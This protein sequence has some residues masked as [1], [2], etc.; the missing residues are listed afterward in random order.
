[1][2]DWFSQFQQPNSGDWF[3]KFQTIDIPEKPQLP[4]L[5]SP[6][7]QLPKFQPTVASKYEGPF[8]F[9]PL[10]RTLGAN[11]G[12][13]A[14]GMLSGPLASEETWA[15]P[16]GK[17]GAVT[18]SL[19]DIAGMAKGASMLGGKLFKAKPKI[20]KTKLASVDLT[21]SLK[22]PKEEASPIQLIKGSENAYIV[23]PNGEKVFN[24]P[25]IKFNNPN[26][27]PKLE[28]PK[29]KPITI[30]KPAP[31]ERI[32]AW[33]NSRR[34]SDPAGLQVERQF[35]DIDA[36]GMGAIQAIE[37]GDP[38]Y[39]KVRQHL[40]TRYN[41]AKEAIPEIKYRKNYLPLLFDNTREEVD[42]A[43]KA[44]EEAKAL[45][46]IKVAKRPG[47]TLTR[48]LED[49]EAGIAKGLKPKFSKPSQILGWYEQALI[50]GVEDRKLF[51][52]LKSE[53][54][55]SSYKKEG[56]EYLDPNS[57][58]KMGNKKQGNVYYA[59]EKIATAINNAI[60]P[61][62][63]PVFSKIANFSRFTK[64]VTLTGG[65]PKTGINWHTLVSIPARAATAQGLTHPIKGV[66]N[67]LRTLYYDVRPAAAQKV[68]D[69]K[70]GR[71]VYWQ[72][73]G[74]NLGAEGFWAG[75]EKA[76]K[77]LARL[78]DWF[79]HASFRQVIPATK[80][81]IADDIQSGLI[82]KGVDPEEA[83]DIVAEYTNTWFGGLNNP[84]RSQGVKDFLQIALLA[85]DWAETKYKITK[86]AAKALLTPG[87]PASQLYLNGVAAMA[88][89][90][91]AAAGIRAS[92]GGKMTPR[93]AGNIPLP[94]LDMP[95]KQAEADP[96]G[97]AFESVE[98]PMRVLNKARSGDVGGVI[99][100]IG[101]TAKNNTSI[102]MQKLVNLIIG[103][104]YYGHPL[105]SKYGN[106]VE[107]KELL[108]NYAREIL[109]MVT[110]QP[111][112]AGVDYGV[113]NKLLNAEGSATG[114]EAAAQA[115]E[116]PI[117]WYRKPKPF[118]N[119]LPKLQK[120]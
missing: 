5:P 29:T 49:Y 113:G 30:S 65:V 52:Y 105:R 17:A 64:N 1:M 114:P 24:Q 99:E 51:E 74:M 97:S 86:G 100:E 27:I 16:Y 8:S 61:K 96:Y 20:S 39:S 69:Q 25:F 53:K 102:P 6:F 14:A 77:G 92:M 59:P 41:I 34:A 115:F 79:S 55:L 58:P 28:A 76:K 31:E 106:E 104:D 108:A 56:W 72:K 57:F 37:S 120:P 2:P 75:Q 90:L 110:L 73:H 119:A 10:R 71:T 44:I 54:L 107:T 35:A 91:G 89:G 33:Y 3:S 9:D 117:R 88:A 84:F 50:K 60:A 43:F 66:K 95:G 94:A 112:Q 7:K 42:T 45:T 36:D 26:E 23:G 62:K 19:L 12:N 48:T 80:I 46:G 78:E 70:L 82:R 116:I 93:R 11:V 111:I 103:E 38:K 4:E 32:T 47:F 67:L 87:N 21:P 98:F 109:D 15:S 118:Q 22:L 63:I 18:G 83:A 68:L 101:T 85:P 81:Q 13:F 40:D